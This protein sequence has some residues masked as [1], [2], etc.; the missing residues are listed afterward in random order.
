MDYIIFFIEIYQLHGMYKQY[1][2]DS[3][4]FFFEYL[5]SY[6]IGNNTK[7]ESFTYCIIEQILRKPL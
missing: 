7:G 6:K 2:Y 4:R 5:F 1:T 3:I